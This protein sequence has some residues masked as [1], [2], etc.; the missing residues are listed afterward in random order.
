MKY[1]IIASGSAGNCVIIERLMIDIGL[2][3]KKIEKYLHKIDVIF[4]THQHTDHVK[5]TTLKQIRKYHP[6]IKILCS[7]ELSEYLQDNELIKVNNYVQ[8]EINMKE[9]K[10]IL[11]PFKC[12]HNVVCQGIV[13]KYGDNY[14]IYATDTSTLEY[15]Y[16]C[17]LGEGVYDYFFIEANYD[18]YKIRAMDKTKYGYDVIKSAMRHLSKQDSYDFY[19]MNRRNVDSEYIQLHKSNRFY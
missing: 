9:S 1:E 8:Y 11:Q 13:F 15:S 6:R 17:T 12:K 16:N 4:I 19:L 7:K 2:S 18:K 14:C 10:L 5:K 3:Y